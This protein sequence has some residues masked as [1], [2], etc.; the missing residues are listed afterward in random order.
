MKQAKLLCLL[1][2]MH[3]LTACALSDVFSTKSVSDIT[4]G[5]YRWRCYFACVDQTGTQ[6]DYVEQRDHCRELAQL[7]VNMA[8][9][10][11]RQAGERPT[12]K[13]T[14]V[15]L[16]SRCMD[17]NGWVV[18]DGRDPALAS[19]PASGLQMRSVVTDDDVEPVSAAQ[20]ASRGSQA[21]R[22]SFTQQNQ[23]YIT[24]QAECAFARSNAHRSSIHASRAK[25]C[26]YQCNEGLRVAPSAPRPAACPALTPSKYTT[27]EVY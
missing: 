27:G 14:L 24:R 13:S 1:L 11:A 21:E 9:K 3:S 4:G 25:A 19:S 17:S 23:A 26:D 10:E 2:I 18:P 15:S 20:T 6:N 7:K 5:K 8:M 12:R 22:K 16:F